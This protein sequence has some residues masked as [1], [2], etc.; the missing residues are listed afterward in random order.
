MI[1][2][3]LIDLISEDD[4]KELTSYIAEKGYDSP[5]DLMK[6]S[7]NR[8]NDYT[9]IDV[10]LVILFD[11][12]TNYK[13]F[14]TDGEI[15]NREQLI[16]KF[17]LVK[18]KFEPE[19]LFNH[20]KIEVSGNDYFLYDDENNNKKVPTKLYNTKI[21]IGKER[22]KDFILTFKLMRSLSFIM[23]NNLLLTD[24]NKNNENKENDYIVDKVLNKLLTN[25]S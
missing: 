25:D 2:S 14:I 1:D 3:E 24:L 4:S 6:Y 19:Q 10:D 9:L 7:E 23:T 11:L 8:Y 12:K 15:Y 22:W 21:Y 20:Q 16:E 5:S 18:F 13:V 17:N